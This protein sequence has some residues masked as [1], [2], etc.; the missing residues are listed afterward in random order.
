MRIKKIES[1]SRR[2]FTAIYRCDYCEFE[3]VSYGYDD[4]N[5]HQNV[6]PKMRCPSCGNTADEYRPMSTKYAEHE[7]I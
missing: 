6:I 3:H 4:S 5:F 7:V 1:Q 2:D